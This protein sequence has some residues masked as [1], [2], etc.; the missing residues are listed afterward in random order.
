[1]RIAQIASIA[2]RVPA[3]KYGGSE[4]IVYT[5]T[6]ELVKRGHDVTL[7]ASGDSVTSAKLSSC[8]PLSLRET[9]I[10]NPYG[11]NELLLKHIGLAY[12]QQDKFDII[13]DH[14]YSVSMPTANLSKTPVVSTVHS[15]FH[16]DNIPLY[17]AMNKVNLVTI[18]DSQKPK[19]EKLTIAGTVYHGLNM[20]HY[21]FG[22]SPKG[23]LLFCGRMSME[24]GVHFAIEAAQKL[25]LPLKIIARVADY[26]L[27]YFKTYVKP[28]LSDS[29]LE[30][31]GEVDEDT[32]NELMAGAIAMLHPVTWPEPFGLTMIESMACG[33]PVVAF[34][35]G[36]IP[37]V[38]DDGKT[39]FVVRTVPE[40]VAAVKKIV[41][42][43]RA[44]CREYALT[45]FTAAKM[46]EGY[47][48]I[49][50][51]ILER[52]N[53]TRHVS[54]PSFTTKPP[55]QPL[56]DFMFSPDFS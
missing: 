23:Y 43:S 39:G 9:N 35:Q 26:E 31:I 4:R 38:I 8:V 53:P 6:E 2:E 17:K 56:S 1:M 50:E 44:Y 27:D 37:E 3:K 7:F 48:K 34:N 51:S 5:L 11:L 52:K 10:Q 15:M 40:M 54:L 25:D 19:N 46:A 33:T 28:Q 18:S 45:R 47:E 13:H 21:P 42:I 20:R 14:I 32:R 12:A 30:F 24:K 36:S 16:Q 29:R 41:T 55:I 22:E 49:Y